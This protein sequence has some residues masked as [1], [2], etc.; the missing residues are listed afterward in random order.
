MRRMSGERC[1]VRRMGLGVRPTESLSD[2]VN[3]PP[4]PWVLRQQV[5]TRYSESTTSRGR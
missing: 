4:Y 1:M 5:D 3:T 2:M